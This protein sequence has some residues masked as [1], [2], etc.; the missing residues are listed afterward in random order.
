M[1]QVRVKVFGALMRPFGKD[2]LDFEV[3]EGTDA[4][5]LLVA[6]GYARQH[7][8]LITILVGEKRVRP[9][10]VLSP[11]EEVSLFLPTQGG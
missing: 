10:Y 7:V 3:A 11:G 6:L 4:E 9:T 8:A 5:G 1:V 2:E